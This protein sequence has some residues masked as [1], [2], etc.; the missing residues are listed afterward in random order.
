MSAAAPRRGEVW[1]ADPDPA[2]GSEIHKRRPVVVIGHDAVNARRRTVVVVPLSTGPTPAPPVI[3]P[4]TCRGRAVTAV[5]DQVRAID[6]ARL[7][8][9]IEPMPGAEVEAV[10]AA[11]R[12]IL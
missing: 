2:V 11:L 4:V 9:F 3:V 6:K 12:E 7:V 5:V 10:R 1:W 8:E